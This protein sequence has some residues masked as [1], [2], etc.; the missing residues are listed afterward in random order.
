MLILGD[1]LSSK[2][3]L[4]GLGDMHGGIDRSEGSGSSTRGIGR[5]GSIRL[6]DGSLL[7]G[8]EGLG[9]AGGHLLGLVLHEGGRDLHRSGCDCSRGSTSLGATRFRG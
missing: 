7:K 8:R 4:G 1:R 5:I 6:L 9:Q 3:L 2:G